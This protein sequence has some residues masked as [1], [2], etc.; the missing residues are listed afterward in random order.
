MNKLMEKTNGVW[1]PI[2]V[3][4]MNLTH[5][6]KLVYAYYL[7]LSSGENGAAFATNYNV[8]EVLGIS[9]STL[10]NKV[11]PSLKRK[12]LITSSGIRTVCNKQNHTKCESENHTPCES[13]NHT[14]CESKNHTKCESENHTPCESENHTPCESKNHTKCESENHTKCESENHT[15]CVPKNKEKKI[16][17]N[18]V[19]NITS[20]LGSNT[21]EGMTI[22]SGVLVPDNT[23]TSSVSSTDEGKES[24]SLQEAF[25]HFFSEGFEGGI[26]T[27]VIKDV[28]SSDDHRKTLWQRWDAYCKW[29]KDENT[30]TS[31]K[32]AEESLNAFLHLVGR[33]YT[34]PDD[35][36]TKRVKCRHTYTSLMKVF[37]LRQWRRFI[38][39]LNMYEPRDC[40]KTRL[41]FFDK[42]AS[43]YQDVEERER[44]QS[45]METEYAEAY[46]A[47]RRNS[48]LKYE[49]LDPDVKYSNLHEEGTPLFSEEDSL[50]FNTPLQ[51]VDKEKETVSD[52]FNRVYA[53]WVKLKMEHNQR[54]KAIQPEYAVEFIRKAGE[55]GLSD[56]EMDLL[57]K[58]VRDDVC[59]DTNNTEPS[60]ASATD[61]MLD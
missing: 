27:K 38:S 43:F 42:V 23:E 56:H 47:T 17:E 34:K 8:C 11:K 4:Q 49:D 36:K 10:N 1:I 61:W 53:G 26:Y 54:G 37:Y 30:D 44:V 6:E 31:F 28:A 40:K 50:L 3:L 58:A 18:G 14:P 45:Q 24:K 59:P 20:Y 13:K 60:S 51:P 57:A 5:V 15:K 48:D 32:K 12:G 21:C 55:T 33:V 9:K 52:T 7:Q 16:K 39:N 46:K 29:L 41:A 19:N 22:S 2:E 35:V 25:H